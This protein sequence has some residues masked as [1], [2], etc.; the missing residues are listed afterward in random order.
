M[1]HWWIVIALLL[2]M[3]TVGWAR[4]AAANEPEALSLD[5][6]L[7]AKDHV[8]ASLKSQ[9]SECEDEV[10]ARR[11]RASE[12]LLIQRAQL[13]EEFRKAL[14]AGPADRFDWDTFQFI[15]ADK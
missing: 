14:G 6:Q 10:K 5:L 3:L 4:R 9:W 12:S 13:V 7:R 15:A 8:I 2:L 11:A 1:K